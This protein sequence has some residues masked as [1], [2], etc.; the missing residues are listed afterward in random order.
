MDLAPVM[1][2]AR[3]MKKHIFM[4]VLD[5]LSSNRLW[6]APY[7]ENDPLS[8]NRYGI[9]EPDHGPRH[10]FAAAQLDLIIM[11]LVAFDDQGNRL[12]MGGG[13]YDRTLSYLCNR[14]YWR[15]PKIIG[16]GYEFQH[17]EH[18]KSESW[19][20]AVNKVISE[21]SVYGPTYI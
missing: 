13:Y 17:I 3:K 1:R 21:T 10:F 2:V 19:D 14:V 7:E 12:G 20:V 11:P 4:P 18:I 8:L 6:F 5:R 9:A 15:R 16:V